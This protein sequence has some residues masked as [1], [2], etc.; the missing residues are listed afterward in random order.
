MDI[1]AHGL[2]AN[3]IFRN[4]PVSTRTLAIVLSIAPDLIPF[5]PSLLNRKAVK[6]WLAVKQSTYEKVAKHVP[7]WVYRLYDITHSIPLW[8]VGF[9]IWW[10]IQGSVPWAAFGWLIHILIDIPT[11]MK[12]FFPTPFLWPFSRRVVDGIN[13]G[14]R[15]FMLA[16]Y[17]ILAA[18]YLYFYV[19]R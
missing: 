1:F 8:I 6:M 15:W 11:H 10:L 3:L 12:S 14:V 4:A 16:N 5:V 19:I 2:W 18:L 7:A 13:W 9:F 17:G